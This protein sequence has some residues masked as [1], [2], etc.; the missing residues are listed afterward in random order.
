MPRWLKLTLAGVAALLVLVILGVVILVNTIDVRRVATVAADET[1]NATGR[2]LE[3]RGRLDISFFPRLAIVA[4]DVSFANAPWGS[5]PEMLTAKRIDGS[6]ALLPL[7]R[8]RI[9]VDRLVLIEPDVL[10]ETNA[11]GVG[12]WE[13]GRPSKTTPPAEAAG[14][15]TLDVRE[16]VIERGT[17]AF[18]DGASKRTERVAVGQLQLTQRAPDDRLD[19]ELQATFREQRFTASGAMGRLV[20]V[21][22]KDTRWPVKLAFATDGA[23]A[24]VDGTV[25]WSVSPP[26]LDA[27]FKAEVTDTAGLG[28]LAGTAIN[29]PVPVVLSVKLASRKGEQVADPLEITLGKYAVAGRATV[30]T[31]GARPVVIARLASKEIDLTPLAAT[32]T[33]PPV[34]GGRVFSDTPLALAPLRA[35]GADAEIAID[36]LVLPNKLPLEAVRVRAT[37]T[38]GRLDVQPLTATLGGGQLTG[39]VQLDA[40]RPAAP[41]LALDIDGKGI[42]LE[43]LATALGYT[44]LSGGAADLAIRLAG[45]GESLHR[46]VGWGNG[47]LRASVGPARVSGAALDIGGGALTSILDKVDPFRRTDPHTDLRC[48][49]VRLPVRDGVATSQRT[50]AAETA[51]VNMA[52]A[53]TIN[54]RTEGLDL[55]IRPT[56]REGLGI[57]TTS[58]AEL[59]RVTGTLAEPA[60]GIDTVGSARAAL[61]VGG[62][63][64]TG[65][66][67]LLGEALFSKAT[68][69][70]H[71]CQTALAGTAPPRG[72]PQERRSGGER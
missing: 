59:V 17:F 40:S 35:V 7:L 23:R 21:L 18:R 55:A 69:D 20:R 44:G 24:N 25:D 6:F 42:S 47:E 65:G 30:R 60:I 43:K 62:A 36:R 57:G 71:P 34:K 2:E 8:G 28:R 56:V 48:L 3:I 31:G 33:S 12:N 39:R 32:A 16:L 26:G 49:V 1:K 13:F 45:P 46:F 72:A 50:I 54:L 51:K 4:E 15:S 41:T 27:T 58:L 22:E 19:V 29:A 14:E 63:V 11:K 61:S 70:R 68:A 5:R 52:L 10:L 9:D 53:G 67:S 64:A 38:A 37:L 66:L